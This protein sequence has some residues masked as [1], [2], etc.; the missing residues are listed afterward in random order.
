MHILIFMILEKLHIAEMYFF[1]HLTLC[2]EKWTLVEF[3]FLTKFFF[4]SRNTFVKSSWKCDIAN[5]FSDRWN[6]LWMNISEV[7]VGCCVF[8][9]EFT[10]KRVLERRFENVF[11]SLSC[12]RQVDMVMR[13]ACGVAYSMRRR[14]LELFFV[15]FVKFTGGI[16]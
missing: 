15:G 11:F 10:R 3:N 7:A 2:K 13:N 14:R 5:T 6:E 12:E 9:V 1:L 16:C 4:R 8:G